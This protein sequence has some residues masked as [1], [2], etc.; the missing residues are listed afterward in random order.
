MW[1]NHIPKPCPILQILNKSQ[2]FWAHFWKQ[3]QPRQ[4]PTRNIL[5]IHPHHYPNKSNPFNTYII[6]VNSPICTN[7]KV[8]YF[9]LFCYCIT[10]S[11]IGLYHKISLF[12]DLLT[13]WILGDSAIFTWTSWGLH[14]STVLFLHWPSWWCYIYFHINSLRCSYLQFISCNSHHFLTAYPTIQAYTLDTC[15][16]ISFYSSLVYMHP[17]Y[18]ILDLNLMPPSQSKHSFLIWNANT[19]QFFIV[20]EVKGLGPFSILVQV[21]LG[22]F[23]FTKW[24]CQEYSKFQLWW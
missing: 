13:R 11:N 5:K 9:N 24:I 6:K 14:P 23:N 19:F 7:T 8:E 10:Y 16:Q 21:K 4:R 20:H 3:I 15:F 12:F 17:K 22:H 18:M 1:W 2:H